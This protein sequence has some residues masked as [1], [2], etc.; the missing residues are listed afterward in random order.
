MITMPI[1]V[2]SADLLAYLDESGTP[3]TRR[4]LFYAFE[5]GKI[6]RPFTTRSGD[7]SWRPEDAGRVIAYFETSRPTSRHR[8]A[9]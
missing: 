9:S 6:P 7:F 8:K 1:G 5:T 4:Q 2:H 3:I